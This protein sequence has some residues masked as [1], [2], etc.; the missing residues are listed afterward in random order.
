MNTV[1]VSPKYQVV[2]PEKIRK[3]MGIK[4][5][6]KFEVIDFEGCLEFV[7]VK[8]MRSLRGS[9]KGLD[10]KGLREKEDRL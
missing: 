10:R 9:L 1:T 8:R 6:Q 2:I 4:P 7:P 5:G 3:Q